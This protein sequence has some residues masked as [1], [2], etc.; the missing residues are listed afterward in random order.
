MKY[1]FLKDC[2]PYKKGQIVEFSSDFWRE[3]YLQKDLIK[4]LAQKKKGGKK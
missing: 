1:R 2:K 3:Y 4:P